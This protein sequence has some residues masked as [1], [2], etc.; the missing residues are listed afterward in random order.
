MLIAA[1]RLK[2]GGAYFEINRIGH[3]KLQHFAIVISQ[4]TINDSDEDLVLYIPK[5]VV[6][7]THTVFNLFPM[8]F[9]LDTVRSRLLENGAFC[10][11]SLRLCGAF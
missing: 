9:D 11:L 10:D 1:R 8:H 7:F 3:M 5:L 6:I 2:K 4:T